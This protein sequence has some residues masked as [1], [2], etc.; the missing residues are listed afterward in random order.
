ANVEE[1]A[2]YRAVN[3]VAP[4]LIRV[5][6]D[7]VTYNLHVL[8]RFELECDLLTGALAVADLPDA[9]NAK[10]QTYLGITPPNDAAAVWQ[11]V[12]W[13]AGLIGY[14]PT[15]SIGNLLSAQ[16]WHALHAAL[17]DLGAQIAAGE[18]APLLD[19]LRQNVHRCGSKYL[20]G[21]LIPR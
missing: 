2:F 13:P 1:E 14:F 16:L 21:E 10:M 6:A 4:S 9:W 11:D 3:K 18:F 15:Y 5:E 8:L 20:P 12:H 19:W 7:E 17:P